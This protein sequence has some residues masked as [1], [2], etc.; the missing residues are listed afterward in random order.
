MYSAA[1][2]LDPRSVTDCA[3]KEFFCLN[4]THFLLCDTSDN[5]QDKTVPIDLNPLECPRDTYCDNK[6]RFECSYYSASGPPPI[7]EDTTTSTTTTTTTTDSQNT[8]TSEVTE[9]TTRITRET[10]NTETNEVPSSTS[11]VN[12]TSISDGTSENNEA[13]TEI[14]SEKTTTSGARYD[15]LIVVIVGRTS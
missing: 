9:S 8:V 3:G 2:Q 15:K 11:S 10:D 7:D 4:A 1:Q 13:T 14:T 12:Y 5:D 6:G